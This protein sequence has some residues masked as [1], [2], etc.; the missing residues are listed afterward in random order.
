MCRVGGGGVPPCPLVQGTRVHSHCLECRH[1]LSLS[2]A[3]H[4]AL[5]GAELPEA[6]F[7]GDPARRALL[8]RRAELAGRDRHRRLQ[9]GFVHS[10]A[11]EWRHSCA[12][13]CVY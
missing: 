12:Q 8:A 7:G 6:W 5:T 9:D 11:L 13:L 1:T 4:G 2:L 3:C 10:F